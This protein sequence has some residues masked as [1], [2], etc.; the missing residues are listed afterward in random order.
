MLAK[1]PILTFQQKV[2]TRKSQNSRIIDWCERE[3]KSGIVQN[4]ASWPRTHRRKT[5]LVVGPAPGS[6]SGGK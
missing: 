5:G 6:E 2:W 3:I 1:V 4:P